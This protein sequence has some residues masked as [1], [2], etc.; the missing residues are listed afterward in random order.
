[1]ANSQ[2]ALR[3]AI[4]PLRSLASGSISG[5][6][7]GIGTNLVF[8]S[9]KLLIQNYTNAQ[10]TFSDDGVNDKFV[11]A[12]GAQFILDEALNHHGDYTAAGTRFYVKGTWYGAS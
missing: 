6:Y 5:T 8:P 4:E 3:L 2:Q 12:S 7:A 1:M 10:L 9:R 11:L